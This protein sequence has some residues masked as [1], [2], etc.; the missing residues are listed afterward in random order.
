MAS[1]RLPGKPLADIHGRPMILHVLARALEAAIGPV[2]VACAEPEI[3]EAVRGAGALA[4]LTDPA[5]PSGS[6]RAHAALAELDPAGHYDVV[7]NVQG[8]FPTLPPGQLRAVLAPLADPMVDIGTLV[9]PIT[10]EAEA[11]TPS[12]VKAACAF[13]EGREV[14]PAL[15]FS[16]TKIPWGEGPRWH[17]IG[18]Y[19]WR[20]A[21][22]SRFVALPPS[23]LERRESLEQL[24]ALEAGMRIGCARVAHA[25][26]GVDTP[27][28]LARARALL[29]PNRPREPR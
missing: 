12:V 13:A 3:A 22:L 25:A 23:A 7:V 27:A 28:D 29:D 2:A 19:A 5:L 18:V 20:R 4:V 17:H 14:A 24:R 11:D 15:Y 26:F 1:T 16:R 21:A 6:D 9:T 10:S 8:D